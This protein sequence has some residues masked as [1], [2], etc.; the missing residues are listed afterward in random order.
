MRDLGVEVV[1]TSGGEEI[2]RCPFHTDSSPSAWFSPKKKLFWCAVC[3]LGLNLVQLRDR[4]APDL[5]LDGLHES[6]DPITLPD[7]DLT[8]EPVVLEMGEELYHDYFKRRGVSADTVNTYG[9]LWKEET[10]SAAV[11]PIRN[12]RWQTIGVMHRYLDPK[13][14]GTRYK[15]QG[16]TTPIWPMQWLLGLED[17]HR[18]MVTEGV[19]SA[20]RLSS[21]MFEGG[22]SNA[23][24]FSL[25]GAKANQE[26]VDTLRPF[27]PVFL[28][29]GDTAGVNACKKM[30]HLAPTWQSYTLNKAPDDCTDIELLRMLERLAERWVRG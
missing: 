16:E 21:F 3:N 4:L 2:V 18:V 24:I 6:L 26:I 22:I 14:T 29:D 17:G 9:L 13:L 30:R 5:D 11:L 10:P 23:I 1:R 12:M 20:M 27:R 19:W 15:I 7:F 25:M 28:Y 8:N